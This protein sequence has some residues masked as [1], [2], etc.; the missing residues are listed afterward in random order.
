MQAYYYSAKCIGSKKKRRIKG[1][2]MAKGTT[3][4]LTW[5]ENKLKY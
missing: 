5:L 2:S 4:R 1:E 3:S